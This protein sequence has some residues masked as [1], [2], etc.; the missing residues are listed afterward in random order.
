M[1]YAVRDFL[2][3]FYQQ[4]WFHY[5]R[6]SSEAFAELSAKREKKQ[7]GRAKNVIGNV[8]PC[9]GRC[10]KSGIDELAVSMRK[11]VGSGQAISRVDG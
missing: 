9:K 2:L 1:N 4:S 6:T 11:P 10:A 5:F 8:G 7:I 3:L